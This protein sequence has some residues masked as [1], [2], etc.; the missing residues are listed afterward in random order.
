[1]A[2]Y[3]LLPVFSGFLFDLPKGRIGFNPIRL[4]QSVFR[5][6][7]SL[8]SG[9][10]TVEISDVM[11]EIRLYEG[12]LCLRELALPYLVEKQIKSIAIDGNLQRAKYRDGMFSFEDGNTTVHSSITVNY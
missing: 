11:T 4:N 5:C 8:N 9:W 2:S 10:G 12:C 7:W 1:M 3:S 6:F